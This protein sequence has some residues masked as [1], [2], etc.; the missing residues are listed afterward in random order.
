MLKKGSSPVDVILA[1]A[2]I[3][4]GK[5][6]QEVIEDVLK[7]FEHNLKATEIDQQLGKVSY[8]AE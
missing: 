1:E 7:Q 2:Q 5:T 3:Q 8:W 6:E 4:T